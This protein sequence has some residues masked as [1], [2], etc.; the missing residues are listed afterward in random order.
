MGI[1]PYDGGFFPLW[2]ARVVLRRQEQIH[3]F[4]FEERHLLKGFQSKLI[5]CP[6][7]NTVLSDRPGMNDC[8]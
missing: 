5:I 8:R 3:D 7:R 6:L 1:D 4:E 2:Y